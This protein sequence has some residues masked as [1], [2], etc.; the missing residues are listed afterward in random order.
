M[1]TVRV[2]PVVALLALTACAAPIQSVEQSD[3]NLDSVK[4]LSIRHAEIDASVFNN[5]VRYLCL[6]AAIA[7]S[8]ADSSR[9]GTLREHMGEFDVTG[10][11]QQY[12]DEALMA[13]GVAV[14]W[15]EPRV[16]FRPRRADDEPRALQRDGFGLRRNYMMGG[17]GQSQLDISIQFAG[18]ASDGIGQEN[19]Y[20]PTVMVNVR[21]VDTSGEQVM[22]Q[23][24]F[25]Y[26]P[27][28][29]GEGTVTIAADADHFY[30]GFDEMRNADPE[31]LRMALDAA[32][33]AVAYRI[34]EEL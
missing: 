13:R 30:P 17:M 3:R 23:N 6:T 25:H 28:N 10:M 26:N 21:L 5:P 33:R 27:I 1:N 31:R 11:F 29:A 4:V 32:L 9:G 16:D 20:R 8:A 19:P 2:V 15:A 34:V 12:L 18:Y 7:A 24:G 22:Y 14:E